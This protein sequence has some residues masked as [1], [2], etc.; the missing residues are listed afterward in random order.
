M[1]AVNGGG[2]KGWFVCKSPGGSRL[3]YCDYADYYM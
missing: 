2:M 3:D 1:S